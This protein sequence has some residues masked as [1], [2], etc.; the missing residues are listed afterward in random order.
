MKGLSI[1]NY[2]TLM[3]EIKDTNKCKDISRLWL[4]ELILLEVYTTQNNLENQYSPNQN[5]KS[6]FHRNRTNN[7]KICMESQKTPNSQAISTKNKAGSFMFLDFKL[8]YKATVINIV[9]YNKEA[10]NIQLG[11]DSLF[12]KWCWENWTATGKRIKLDR[13]LIP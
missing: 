6:I 12:N 1:D 4:E 7:P 10:K 9:C 3:K 2:K 13:Y 11:K 5:P 8:Y